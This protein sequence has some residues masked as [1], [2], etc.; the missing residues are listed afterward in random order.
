MWGKNNILFVCMVRITYSY[1]TCDVIAYLHKTFSLINCCSNYIFFFFH[2]LNFIIFIY[3]SS[4]FSFFFHWSIYLF[5]IGYLLSF[6]YFHFSSLH[7]F[8]LFFFFHFIYLFS[9][10]R[11][12]FFFIFFIYLFICEYIFCGVCPV[13]GRT[14]LKPVQLNSIEKI[15]NKKKWKISKK[16]IYKN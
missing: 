6:I 12:I 14:W 10:F 13:V 16:Y 5:S 9:F 15:S 3:F 1:Q 11:F 2:S 7:L 4:F 8:I